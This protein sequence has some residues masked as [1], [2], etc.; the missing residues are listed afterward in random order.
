MEQGTGGDGMSLPGG[1]SSVADYGRERASR[2]IEAQERYTQEAWLGLTV[3]ER[4]N[5]INW[6]EWGGRRPWETDESGGHS[7]PPEP[8]APHRL[9]NG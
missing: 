3:V 6:I 1:R 8:T 7:Y 9:P 4:G 5:I 2:L